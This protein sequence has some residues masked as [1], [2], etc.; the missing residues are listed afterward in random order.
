[1]QPLV[2]VFVLV[3]AALKAALVGLLGAPV[4]I[5]E[6]AFARLRLADAVPCE[7][8]DQTVINPTEHK[9]G[10]VDGR[11][12]EHPRVIALE[13]RQILGVPRGAPGGKL[14]PNNPPRLKDPFRLLI[15]RGTKHNSNMPDASRD[16]HGPRDYPALK[17]T[18][19]CTSC[20]YCTSTPG[21]W[22][23]S[24]Q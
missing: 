11:R 12:R 6:H 13:R 20:V 23:V 2:L 21:A 18:L 7:I 4:V 16:I 9:E 3:V 1:M 8:Q 22:T 10:R 24:C 14:L 5:V 17:Y 19:H 15:S